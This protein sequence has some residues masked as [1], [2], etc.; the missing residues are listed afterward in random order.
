MAY[1]GPLGCYRNS[2]F[3]NIS[4]TR[5]EIARDSRLSDSKF[6]TGFQVVLYIIDALYIMYIQG[7]P[8]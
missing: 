1:H 7:V 3:I 5:F 2:I 6:F 8:R 4:V